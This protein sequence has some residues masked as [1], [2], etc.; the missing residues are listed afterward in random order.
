[1]KT[2]NLDTGSPIAQSQVAGTYHSLKIVISSPD[3]DQILD[4]RF[5]TSVWSLDPN[6]PG[7]NF[8]GALDGGKTNVVIYYLLL[9]HQGD[10]GTKTK[11]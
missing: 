5:S 3:L 10:R 8:G 1:M 4:Q 7:K 9:H 6:Q 11:W 2:A